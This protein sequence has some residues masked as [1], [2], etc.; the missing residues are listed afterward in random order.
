MVF[1]IACY[2]HPMGP[3]LRRIHHAAHG[4]WCF[5]RNPLLLHF[6]Y[7]DHWA[8]GSLLC[9]IGHPCPRLQRE[10]GDWTVVCIKNT[11]LARMVLRRWAH[12]LFH[13]LRIRVPSGHPC[14][15]WA[16]AK[17]RVVRTDWWK[18]DTNGR[19]ARIHPAWIADRRGGSW[20]DVPGRHWS[21]SVSS[22]GWRSQFR[23]FI[24]FD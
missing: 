19:W 17:P 8:H 11:F 4:R 2:C 13:L 24:N 3:C 16:Q 7:L 21:Q 15:V 12:H 22:L 6:S 20:D 23:N 1:R 14:M 5:R 9:S 10:K 18:G